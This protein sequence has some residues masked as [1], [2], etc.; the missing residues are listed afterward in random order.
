[1]VEVVEPGLG[2]LDE[3]AG[4]FDSGSSRRVRR[5]RRPLGLRGPPGSGGRSLC[6]WG[7]GLRLRGGAGGHGQQGGDHRDRARAILS[8]EH[9]PDL[10]NDAPAQRRSCVETITGCA[11]YWGVKPRLEWVDPTSIRAAALGP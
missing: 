3:L 1:D 6:G 11:V 2:V 7:R 10:L 4:L 5:C 9:D 8:L